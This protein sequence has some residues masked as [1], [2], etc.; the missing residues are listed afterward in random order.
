[1]TIT[2]LVENT[3][4]VGL[5]VEHG[6]SLYIRLNSGKRIL[7]DMGQGSLFAD[8]AE[9][10]GLSIED[11]DTVILSHGHYDHGGGLKTFVS[12]N[13]RAKVHIHRNAFEPHYS[14]RENGLRYIGWN[15]RTRYGTA[16]ACSKTGNSCSVTTSHR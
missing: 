3:S 7:F 13:H 14:L 4:T 9:R 1:M 10:L 12:I 5:P 11:I 8:N 2:S 6:L 16:T 15:P